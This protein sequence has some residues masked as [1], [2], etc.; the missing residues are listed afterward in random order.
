[1]I[2]KRD[3]VIE[4]L[5]THLVNAMDMDALLG[6]AHEQLTSY[7]N[8]LSDEDLTNECDNAEFP[9]EVDE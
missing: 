8:K 6:Y 7:F 9:I 5:A 3:V 2:V 1:M 4:G